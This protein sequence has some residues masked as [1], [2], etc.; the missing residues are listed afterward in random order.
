MEASSRGPLHHESLFEYQL[1][2]SHFSYG[3]QPFRHLGKLT[4]IGNCAE[5]LDGILKCEPNF[6]GYDVLVRIGDV[7]KSIAVAKD[8]RRAASHVLLSSHIVATFISMSYKNFVT[9]GLATG[10]TGSGTFQ[11]YFGVVRSSWLF[12]AISQ[13]MAWPV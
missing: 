4:A 6:W 13:V 2:L 5:I 12:I 11:S 7:I 1:P 8:E 3:T 10:G 9:P